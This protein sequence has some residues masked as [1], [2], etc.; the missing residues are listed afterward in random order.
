MH[1][2]LTSM[3]VSFCAL[4]LHAVGWRRRR[5]RNEE[6]SWEMACGDAVPLHIS[7][8]NP[9]RSYPTLRLHVNARPFAHSVS[10]CP[11]EGVYTLGML[12]YASQV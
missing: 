2:H 12:M 9:L 8:E 3:E 5:V 6:V 10:S 7:G 4:G 11:N 1:L